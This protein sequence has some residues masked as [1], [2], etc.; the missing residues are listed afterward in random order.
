MQPAARVIRIHLEVIFGRARSRL[1]NGVL[2]APNGPFRPSKRDAEGYSP[3]SATRTTIY[4]VAG[5]LDFRT[6]IRAALN[7]LRIQKSP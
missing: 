3:L 4:L 1:I 5:K 6:S 7:P 2:E